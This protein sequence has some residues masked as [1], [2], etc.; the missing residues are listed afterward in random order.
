MSDPFQPLSTAQSG[1]W[2]AQQLDP[3]NPAFNI[4]GYLE[5]HGPVDLPALAE[6]AHRALA[7]TEAARLRFGE[8]GGEPMQRI[9]A[10]PPRPITVL[11]LVDEQDPA[12]AAQRWMR[13]DLARPVDVF[14]DDLVASALLS[15]SS[16][17][18]LYYL[19]F[20][21][22]VLDA[23]AFALVA[24]RL[25]ELYAAR[26]DGL[27]LPPATIG[28]LP[29]VWQDE[30]VYRASARFADDRT[31]WLERFADRP[32]VLSL[33]SRSGRPARAA[34]HVLRRRVDLSTVDVER[35][36][37]AIPRSAWADTIVATTA[38][39]VHRMTGATD[40]VLGFPV[41]GR[42]GRLA[43]TTPGMMMTVLPLRL[44]VRPEMSFADVLSA[45]SRE[46]RQVLRHQRY[47]LEELR[48]DLGLRGEGHR[49]FGPSVNVMPFGYQAP[50]AGHVTVSHVLE[51]GPIEDISFDVY[52]DAHGDERRGRVRIDVAAN[53]TLYTEQ[54]VTAHLDRF[55]RL[56]LDLAE[57]PRT[58]VDAVDLL[59]ERE[60]QTVLRRWQGAVHH[61]PDLSLVTLLERQA[62][63]TPDA[64]A[65]VGAATTLGRPYTAPA[66][67]DAAPVDPDT[68]PAAGNDTL[69]YRQ[70]H[71][72][73]NR[74]AHELIRRG[75][76]PG[77][78]VVVALP[79]GT[80]QVVALLAVL[81]AGG[82]YLPLD[83]SY[84]PDRVEFV[85]QDAKPAALLA[86]RRSLTGLP[87]AGPRPLVLDDPATADAVRRQRADDPTDTDR[88]RTLRADDP[89]YVLYTSGSTGRPKG[90]VVEHRALVNHLLWTQDRFAF[91]AADRVLVKTPATFDVSVWEYFSPLLAGA[92]AVL[93][94]PDGHRDPRYLAELVRTER[95]TATGFVPS[96]LREFLDEPTAASCDS[97]RL[98]LCI[99]EIL[100]VDLAARYAA[101]LGPGLHNLYG[102][103]EATVAVTDH[104]CAES[105]DPAYGVPIGRPVW[106]TRCYVLDPDGR[107]VPV[108]VQGELYLAGAQ[109]ARGYLHRPALTAERFLPDPFGPP[110]SRM[111]RTGDRV[112]HL[113]DGTL[114]FV[115]RGDSQLKVRGHRIEPGEIEACLTAHPGVSQAAVV[116]H[117][118]GTEPR[119]AGYVVP[120]P[121]GPAPGPEAL[122][123]HLAARL[124][125]PMVPATIQILAEL[126]STS[127]GKLDRAALP[128]PAPAATAT[129]RAPRTD[130]EV[131]LCGLF[132]EALDLPLVGVDDDFFDLGG[133]SLRAARL[134][135]RL[136][137]VVGVE[138]D[139]RA[140]FEH[141]TVAGLAAHLDATAVAPTA[142]DTADGRPTALDGVLPLRTEGVGVPLFCL[143]PVTGLSWCYSVLLR[144]I[145]PGHPVYGLQSPGLAPDD[146]VVPDRQP[147]LPEMA[148][149][150]ADDIDSVYPDGPCHLLGWS[151]GGLLAWAT[152]VE[153]R[154]RGRDVPLLALLDAYPSDPVLHSVEHRRVLLD[155]V[156]S[157][158]GYD[159]AILDG[160]SLEEPDVVE[161]IQ[162]HPG[163][164]ADWGPRRIAGLL[165][166]ALHNMRAARSYRPESFDGDLLF[167]TAMQSRPI[168]LQTVD[169]WRPFVRGRISEL[170]LDCRHEHMMRPEAVARIGPLLAA[171]R[172]ALP[173]PTR[174]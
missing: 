166:V 19:R 30:Q 44:E 149:G 50:V 21:H 64:V 75:V 113:A 89:V 138:L 60:R 122:R 87:N 101:V 77:D 11:D 26:T 88:R 83:G 3:E 71:T 171:H 163:A 106:S 28:S 111:Y 135:N 66:D 31:F 118:A 81:K 131:V 22:V 99:G 168:N 139:L 65:L 158:F 145:D 95:V 97:L 58:T 62:A 82:A 16:R 102:P 141:P 36:R 55:V 17:L 140:V 92:T 73:A 167:F 164:L 121:A 67:P 130:R 4:G 91:G 80:A 1:I 5:I 134:A 151:L 72:R 61:L 56:L 48:A 40:V 129:G 137:T 148:V 98:T 27:P 155:V 29:R 13:A 127:N 110:G 51:S 124:P 47:R 20:H 63:V 74:L 2:F 133:H 170:Q 128:V 85:L 112:R 116:A 12:A 78:L 38:V 123:T 8:D 76:G 146:T 43:K 157:D 70:L 150:F 174:R 90:V 103:V 33:S 52:G 107:P 54:D 23:Y 126:P 125:A 169:E 32:E 35:L 18:H 42:W 37:A 143:P 108:G 165:R 117:T 53:P 152:A 104:D 79:R 10:E 15:V 161:V 86:D 147:T 25:A 144:H 46:V 93:A 109:V 120:A 172:R 24:Q 100:P 142:P 45:A 49:L 6:A 119:L 69:T 39:Y 59:D 96:M 94:R 84:P 132:A 159:P 14:G 9:T 153:L 136:R 105:F 57:R 115:G 7:E 173:V 41:T 162:R 160:Q 154:R 114:A 34:H 156:L 68:V